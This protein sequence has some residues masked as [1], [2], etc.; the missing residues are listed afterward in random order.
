MNNKDIEVLTESLVQLLTGQLK[1]GANLLAVAGA[2][3]RQG[4]NKEWITRALSRWINENE[5]AVPLVAGALGS[6]GIEKIKAWV[7]RHQPTV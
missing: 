4:K 1:V 6:T 2:L 7:E 5:E 3:K